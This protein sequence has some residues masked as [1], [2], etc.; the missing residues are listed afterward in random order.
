M[1]KK[2]IITIILLLFCITLF[3]VL[4]LNNK[5]DNYDE[6]DVTSIT[7]REYIKVSDNLYYTDGLIEEKGNEDKEIILGYYKKISNYISENYNGKT[8]YVYNMNYDTLNKENNGITFN[9]YQLV[10]MTIIEGSSTVVEMENS[11]VVDFWKNNYNPYKD[12]LN[13][14]NGISVGEAKRIAYNLALK[15]KDIIA[16]GNDKI[17]GEIYLEYNDVDGVYYKVIIN[18][19][20]Y[21]KIDVKNGNAID[22]YYDDG[23]RY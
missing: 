11:E 16:S 5:E 2:I 15:N 18:E 13:K 17:E 22:E 21:I 19:F 12:E 6:V 9:L 20:S 7:E 1:K 3:V 8:F 14:S 4:K 23:I 10:D